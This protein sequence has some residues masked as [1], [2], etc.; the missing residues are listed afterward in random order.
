MPIDR[1]V[2]DSSDAVTDLCQLGQETGA[3]KSPYNVRAHRHPYTA[4]YTMLFAPL[5]SAPVVFSE[6]GVA[7]GASVEMWVKYFTNPDAK[8][9][10]FDR[11]ENFLQYSDQRVEDSRAQFALMDV[12]VD[13]DITR[14]LGDLEYDVVVDD[15]SHDFDHQIRIA[16]EALP[17]LK[18]GGM[19]IIEDIFRNIPEEDFE[20]EL[21]DVLPGC[22]AAYFV[23]CEHKW[24]WSPGWD[25]DKMLVLV[26]A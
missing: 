26:R 19:L 1:I 5:R 20:R 2:I 21:K 10:F 8:F 12:K 13:G 11:D 17:K 18:R 14:G 6:I 4:V 22:A 24:K 16:K 9:R 15:S 7:G 3:D 25:N 23:M